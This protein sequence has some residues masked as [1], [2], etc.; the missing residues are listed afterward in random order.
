MFTHSVL[1]GMKQNRKGHGTKE[2]ASK[3]YETN[4]KQANK[5]INQIFS[6]SSKCYEDLIKQGSV[7][8]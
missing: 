6:G 2:T 8:E 5:E 1:D 7:I 3:F 4:S